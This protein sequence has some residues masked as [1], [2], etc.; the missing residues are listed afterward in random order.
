MKTEIVCDTVWEGRRITTFLIDAWSPLVAQFNKHRLTAQNTESSRAMSDKKTIRRRTFL[1]TFLQNQKGMQAGPPLT[2]W[3]NFFAIL[4]WRG[5]ASFTRMGCKLLFALGVHKEIANRP[6]EWFGTKKLLFTAEEWYLREIFFPLRCD[7]TAQGEFQKIANE[8]RY[9][10]ENNKPAES[11]EHKPFGCDDP[12]ECAAMCARISFGGVGVPRPGDMELGNRLM[13]DK[14]W[15]A[16][17]HWC[18]AGPGDRQFRHWR[19]SRE[20]LD[21]RRPIKVGNVSSRPVSGG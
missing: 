18:E 5:M 4:L 2:G 10:F 16:F 1:P 13:R 7:L 19:S 15:S 3:R 17:E 6:L 11:P 21:Q 20:W 9:L 14:H 8:M 12:V